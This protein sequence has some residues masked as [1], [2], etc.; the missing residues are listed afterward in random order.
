MMITLTE[1]CQSRGYF[2]Q[3]VRHLI[4]K[5]LLPEDAWQVREGEI[6]INEEKMDQAL[7]KFR[8]PKPQRPPRGHWMA[9]VYEKLWSHDR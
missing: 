5:T 2:Q 6:F 9:S 3:Q 7:K 8:P 1:Y 4:K